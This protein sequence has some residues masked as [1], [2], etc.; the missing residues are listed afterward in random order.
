MTIINHGSILGVVTTIL[1]T[2]LLGIVAF[3]VPY[4]KAVYFL[5]AAITNNG[6]PFTIDMGVLGYCGSLD[7]GPLLC[8]APKVGYEVGQSY[9]PYL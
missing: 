7:G 9:F 8:T 1:A 4:F 3:D 5:R 6:T 2:I